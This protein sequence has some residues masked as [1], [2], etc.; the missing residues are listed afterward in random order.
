MPYY[1]HKDK[2]YILGFG[3]PL[4]TF[5]LSVIEP[6]LA[7]WIGNFL[8]Q[9]L[10]I[11]RPVL[12]NVESQTE[13]NFVY[14]IGHVGAENEYPENIRLEFIPLTSRNKTI[15][16]SIVLIH[17]ESF[18]SLPLE[19]QNCY[20]ELVAGLKAEFGEPQSQPEPPKV[21]MATNVPLTE[22]GK[23]AWEIYKKYTEAGKPRGLLNQLINEK[24]LSKQTYDSW[25][26]KFKAEQNK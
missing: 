16:K 26:K 24:E 12:F 19:V 25:R 4:E 8:G 11:S 15:V 2:I 5:E 18:Q 13:N 10:G 6:N 22:L 14:S 21:E 20:T 23:L 1:F 9:K 7:S 17:E 3:H